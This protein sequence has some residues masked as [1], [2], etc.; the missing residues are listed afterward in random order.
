MKVEDLNKIEMR[1]KDVQDEVDS[2]FDEYDSRED[3]YYLHP[4]TDYA[5]KIDL[6]ESDLGTFTEE[7]EFLPLF[8][9][10][11]FE[12]AL[13]TLESEGDV[14]GHYLLSSSGHIFDETTSLLDAIHIYFNEYSYADVMMCCEVEIEP[15]DHA[16]VIKLI[17]EYRN[18]KDIFAKNENK[19]REYDEYIRL[20][21]KYEGK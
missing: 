20:K 10:M 3:M 17:N 6:L 2:I 8:E 5:E 1:M 7:V 4:D 12:E 15:A 13:N 14:T 18:L 16:S 11:S 9:H 21:R 19:I